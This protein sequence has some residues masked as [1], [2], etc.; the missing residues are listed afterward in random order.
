MANY[1]V[2]N[3]G[4]SGAGTIGSPWGLPDLLTGASP[5]APGI[6]L[7]TLVAGDTLYFRGGDYHVTGSSTWQSQMIAPTHSGTLAQPITLS[8]YPG[9]FPQ[10]I[11]DGSSTQDVFG[12]QG[13]NYVRFL[14]FKVVPN[15]VSRSFNIG[16]T[17]CEVGYCEIEGTFQSGTDNHDGILMLD[18]LGGWIHHCN[19]HGQTGDSGNATGIKLYNCGVTTIEDNYSHGNT[20]GMVDKDGGPNGDGFHHGTYRRNLLAGNGYANFI[21][22]G[23]G[24]VSVLHMYDNVI[25]GWFALDSFNSGSEIYNNLLRVGLDPVE[26]NGG[27]NTAIHPDMGGSASSFLTNIWNNIFIPATAGVWSY[28]NSFLAFGVGGATDPLNYLDYNVY[29]GA[30]TYHFGGAGPPLTEYTLAQIQA[31]SLETHS[32]VDTAANIFVN[33]TAYVLKGIYPTAGR[34]GDMVGPRYSVASIL[35]TTRYGPAAMV[36]GVSTATGGPPSR[37]FTSSPAQQTAHGSYEFTSSPAQPVAQG[38]T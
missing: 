35:D 15:A 30:P 10:I 26:T 32:I 13:Y 34:F 24:D 37:Q 12:S 23:Q 18:S 6:A 31:L 4:S 19:I 9:E 29:T 5:N 2:S 16:G 27:S 28:W 7:T 22:P 38:W 21:G 3:S 33:Q 25:D 11:V 20:S 14:G 8:A 17:G 1:Y 36:P